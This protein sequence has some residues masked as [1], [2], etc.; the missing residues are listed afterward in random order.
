[1][2]FYFSIIPATVW[3]IIGFFLLLAS[4]KAKGGL[5]T[6][7]RVLAIWSFVIAALFPL[8]H[9]FDNFLWQSPMGV[10]MEQMHQ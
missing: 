1:M 6:L 10:V 5:R 4:I 8:S 3:V 2:F 7:G 9:A